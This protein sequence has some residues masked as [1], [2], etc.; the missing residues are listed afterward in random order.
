MLDRIIDMIDWFL[1]VR[2]RNAPSVNVVSEKYELNAPTSEEAI[3]IATKKLIGEFLTADVADNLHW[4]ATENTQ[5]AL[6]RELIFI[7]T[8]TRDRRKEKL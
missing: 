6:T 2:S 7:L 4:E 5:V 8:P 1:F 3:D